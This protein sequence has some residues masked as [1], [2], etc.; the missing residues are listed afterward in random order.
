MTIERAILI[1]AVST[2]AT[3]AFEAVRTYVRRRHEPVFEIETDDARMQEATVRARSTLDTFWEA[4]RAKRQIDT[5]FG[6]KCR[7]EHWGCGEQIWCEPQ[8]RLQGKT[9][10]KLLNIPL[11]MPNS[12]GDVVYVTDDQITDWYVI[13]AGEMLG[14]ETQQI[15]WQMVEEGHQPAS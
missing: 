15:L 5:D 10:V 3:I 11:C 9:K 13:R 6:L 4:F 7:F 2:I 1:L 8:Q 12:D 14:G